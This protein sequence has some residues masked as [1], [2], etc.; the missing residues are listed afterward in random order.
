MFC[1]RKVLSF[2]KCAL[3]TAHEFE[4][5]QLNIFEGRPFTL[6]HSIQTHHSHICSS[7]RK[8][9]NYAIFTSSNKGSESGYLYCPNHSWPCMW[10]PLYRKI[11][12][13]GK[14][15]FFFLINALPNS[16]TGSVEFDEGAKGVGC[17]SIII[18]GSER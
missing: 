7:C 14:G 11:I 8:I 3:T 9:C 4:K 12:H 16:L 1:G 2:S 5:L 6:N 17:N 15:S 10:S 18:A 13:T